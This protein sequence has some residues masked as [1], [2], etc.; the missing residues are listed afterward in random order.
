[1]TSAMASGTPRSGLATRPNTSTPDPAPSGAPQ[2]WNAQIISL[3]FLT[4]KLWNFL[5]GQKGARQRNIEILN[6]KWLWR[7]KRQ[8]WMHSYKLAT[9]KIVRLPIYQHGLLTSNLRLAPLLSC[10]SC[11]TFHPSQV[12]C[13]GV[14]T[15]RNA[16][17]HQA[18][19]SQ[20]P[21]AAAS[22]SVD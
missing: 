1:M 13:Q 2:L 8:V 15:T 21:S 11:Q 20:C 22:P 3:P 10:I 7:C 9:Q 6:K 18:G 16:C 17:F 19:T 12:I 4:R 14:A 5:V